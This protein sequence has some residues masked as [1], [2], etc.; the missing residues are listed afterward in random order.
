MEVVAEKWANLTKKYFMA[1]LNKFL[2]YFDSIFLYN[3]QQQQ[4]QGLQQQQQQGLPEK[5]FG[6]FGGVSKNFCLQ[7]QH[8]Q[9]QQQGQ[10]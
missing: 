1:F 3:L 2:L 4:Q 8:P 9:P 5:N 6:F 10:S 7:Q